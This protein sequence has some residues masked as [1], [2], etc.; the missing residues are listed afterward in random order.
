[1]L[2]IT[3]RRVSG[4][5]VIIDSKDLGELVK[6]ANTVEEVVIEEVEEDLPT[7]GL[8]KLVETDEAFAFLHDPAE[9]IYTVD[10]LK[11]RY[12]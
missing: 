1:M 4:D 5:L 8:M 12:R 2:N 9:D 11:E 3:L 6:R 10:D 7:E